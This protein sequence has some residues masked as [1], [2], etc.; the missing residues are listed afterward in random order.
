MTEETHGE[1][2]PAEDTA[3]VL[4]DAEPAPQEQ[5]TGDDAAAEPQPKRQT[6]Q[7]RIDELTR[8]RRDAERREEQAR[9]DAEHWRDQALRTQPKPDPQPKADDEPDPA[10]YEYGESDLGYI[11]DLATHQA[12]RAVRAEFAA[13][14]REREARAAAASWQSRM[15]QAAAKHA[16]FHEVV[17]EGAQRNA[18]DCTPTMLQ[19]LQDSEVGGDL[20]YHLAKNPDDARR[21][22]AL[23]PV[24]QVRE[25][26]RLE[27]KLSQP[28][29]AQPK[30]VT[31]A[32][33]PTPQVRGAGGRFTVAPDTSDFAAFEAQHFKRS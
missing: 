16:D 27:A 19:A 22:A 2:L 28:Q 32:P 29:Q 24:S 5:P 21:I 6:A 11:R 33:D 14:E 9:R 25:L 3:L 30:T 18:W 13:A 20:A 8:L 10:R 15:S 23:S 26:G 12:T 1:A 7:D 17:V 31:A 4:N